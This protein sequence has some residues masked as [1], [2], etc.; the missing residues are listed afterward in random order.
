[1]YDKPYCRLKAYRQRQRKEPTD[2]R[3]HPPKR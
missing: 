3:L 2:A 1:V